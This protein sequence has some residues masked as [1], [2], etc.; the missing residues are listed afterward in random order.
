METKN[1]IKSITKKYRDEIWGRFVRCVHEYELIA[2]GDKIAVCVSGGKDSF[3]L[4]LC[5][6]ELQR[7]SLLAGREKFEVIF[8]CMNP[9]YAAGTLKAV[10]RNAKLLK[11]PLTFFKTNIF[12]AVQNAGD[13]PCYLCAKMRR[14]NLYAEAK[15]LDCNK[16]ALAHHFDDV[17]ETV[18]MNLIYQGRIQTMLPKLKSKNFA[19]LQLIRPFCKVRERDIIKWR[20][21]NNLEFIN[22]ACPLTETQCSV[23]GEKIGK[24][25]EVKM[26]LSELA[27]TNAAAPQN[28]YNAMDKVNINAVLGYTKDGTHHSFLDNFND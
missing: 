28:I 21:S 27:E 7:Q 15:R 12:A 2:D 19:G 20:I 18:M 9:G 26:L 5:M 24:R 3:C 8:L 10:K 17:I 22:C 25:M 13:S 14:G 4:A 6:Q 1:Y 16:I 23:S 11:I